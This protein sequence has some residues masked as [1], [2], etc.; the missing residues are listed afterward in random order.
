MFSLYNKVYLLPAVLGKLLLKNI[1]ITLLGTSIFLI[2]RLLSR[3]TL[4]FHSK[5]SVTNEIIFF[6]TKPFHNN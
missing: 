2:Y 6:F 4:L 1:K 5:I 3:Y